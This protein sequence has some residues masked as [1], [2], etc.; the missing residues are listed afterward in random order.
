MYLNST[1]NLIY[2][3]TEGFVT[4]PTYDPRRSVQSYDFNDGIEWVFEL[5]N[6]VMK[7]VYFH[8]VYYQFWC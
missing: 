3:Y 4:T 6:P 7:N 1:P 8:L 2:L 5:K